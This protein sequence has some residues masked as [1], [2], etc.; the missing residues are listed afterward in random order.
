MHSQELH[1]DNVKAIFIIFRFLCTFRFQKFKFK[2]CPILANH[3]PMKAYLFSFQM[4]YTFQFPKMYPYDW[5]VVQGHILLR[6]VFSVFISSSAL[7]VF[8]AQWCALCPFLGLN[9]KKNT[10]FYW[11]LWTIFSQ[12]FL[13]FSILSL[14]TLLHINTVWV[15]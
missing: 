12:Y 13:S 1:L 14:L 11:N 10:Y 9:M 8:I 15:E 6:H 5:F 4:M 2:Y 7:H 3:T